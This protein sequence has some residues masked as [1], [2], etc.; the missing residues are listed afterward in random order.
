MEDRF[1]FMVTCFS[2][3]ALEEDE[4]KDFEKKNSGVRAVIKELLAFDDIRKLFA[5][6]EVLIVVAFF[7][8]MSSIAP[9]GW[10]FSV[11]LLIAFIVAVFF[12][13]MLYSAFYS[14][15]NAGKED[16]EHGNREM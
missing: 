12:F 14:Y 5:F 13:R 15:D 4:R 9:S 7:G 2:S 6:I 8:V 16:E 3:K 1:G 11:F 10:S